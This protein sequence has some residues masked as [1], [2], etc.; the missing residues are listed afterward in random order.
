MCSYMGSA[1]GSSPGRLVETDE[2]YNI[3]HQVSFLLAMHTVH[4]IV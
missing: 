3:I 1:V 2:N 4:S